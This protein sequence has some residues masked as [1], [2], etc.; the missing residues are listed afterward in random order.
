[1]PS[2]Q[3]RSPP[4]GPNSQYSL[5][6]QYPATPRQDTTY[7]QDTGLSTPFNIAFPPSESLSGPHAHFPS[8]H[9]IPVAAVNGMPPGPQHLGSDGSGQSPALSSLRSVSPRSAAALLFWLNPQPLTS[10][11]K[12]TFRGAELYGPTCNRMRVFM[13]IPCPP[14]QSD[15]HR[16][17]SNSPE[18]MHNVQQLGT[19]WMITLSSTHSISVSC[20]IFV[21]LA[22]AYIYLV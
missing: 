16:K 14:N 3:L 8:P 4:S 17:Q 2:P 21:I 22:L 11:T 12:Y 6:S 5:E 7:H 20:I 10:I 18:D 13:S 15:G 9:Q 1:M 19:L